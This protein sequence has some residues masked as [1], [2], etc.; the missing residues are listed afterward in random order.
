MKDLRPVIVGLDNPHSD[1]PEH[2]L[3]PHPV[4][5][6]GHR[7]YTMMRDANL[8]GLWITA[9]THGFERR[10]LS[11][12]PCPRSIETRRALWS[13]LLADVDGDGP[14]ER[15]VICCGNQVRDAAGLKTERC[16]LDEHR[17]GWVPHPSGMCRAYNDP[18]VKLEVGRFL[19]SLLVDD[20]RRTS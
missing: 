15:V 6:A 10:N 5:C 1:A 2:A 7:L 19:V 17:I 12:Y 11:P 8:S 13:R 4:G 14:R 18:V 20:L 9:Y 3:F 16:V